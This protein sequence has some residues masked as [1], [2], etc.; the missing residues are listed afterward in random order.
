MYYTQYKRCSII[1]PAFTNPV[2]SEYKNSQSSSAPQNLYSKHLIKTFSG[3]VPVDF[4]TRTEGGGQ[5]P[6][7]TKILI[8]QCPSISTI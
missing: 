8:S 4:G 5:P 7:D 6:A 2:V 3:C 1:L